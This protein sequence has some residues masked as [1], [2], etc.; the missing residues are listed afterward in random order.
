MKCEEIRMMKTCSLQSLFGE[1]GVPHTMNA[2]VE[3]YDALC[4][5]RGITRDT[6]PNFVSWKTDS[7]RLA[8]ALRLYGV[9][10]QCFALESQYKFAEVRIRAPWDPHRASALE[11]VSRLSVKKHHIRRPKLK[12]KWEGTGGFGPGSSSGPL[13]ADRKV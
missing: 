9:G 5:I 7:D 6:A 2:D 10:Y 8:P 12:P 3:G 13:P 11:Q 4:C 1:H